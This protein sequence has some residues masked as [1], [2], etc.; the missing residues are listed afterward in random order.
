MGKK[1]K[2]VKYREVVQTET[3]IDYLEGLV[4]GLRA[5]QV[6]LESG[7]RS[8]HFAPAGTTLVEVGVKADEDEQSFKLKLRWRHEP[9]REE[10][11]VAQLKISAEKPEVE[12]TRSAGA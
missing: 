5:G 11:P 7:E 9:E 12:L 3:V 4:A 2:E 8:V 6:A 1:A 10:P